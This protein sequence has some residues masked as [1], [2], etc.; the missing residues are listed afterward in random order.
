MLENRVVFN[1]NIYDSDFEEEEK[2]N[3]IQKKPEWKRKLE[4]EV[5]LEDGKE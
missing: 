2:E 1:N 4:Y 5:G 3:E